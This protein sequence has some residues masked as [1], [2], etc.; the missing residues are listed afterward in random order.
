MIQ[1]SVFPSILKAPQ[2]A[3]LTP[4]ERRA[5]SE[6]EGKRSARALSVDRLVQQDVVF[7]LL[8]GEELNTW[9]HWGRIELIDWSCWFVANWSQPQGGAGVRRFVGAPS[10]PKYFANVGWLVNATVQVRG[11]GELPNVDVVAAPAPTPPDSSVPMITELF[12]G[13]AGSVTGHAPSLP[14]DSSWEAF[15]DDALSGDGYL[16]LSYDGSDLTLTTPVTYP[17]NSQLNINVKFKNSDIGILVPYFQF[18]FGGTSVFLQ[19]ESG[20][21]LTLTISSSTP[22]WISATVD[23]TGLSELDLLINLSASSYKVTANG[24][25]VIDGASY[26]STPPNVTPLAI[27]EIYLA[28]DQ[29]PT[30]DLRVDFVTVSRG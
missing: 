23:I 10:Y 9:L 1:E 29:T 18:F 2:S 13:D 30:P 15:G 20:D 6:I 27:T 28:S 8:N 3:M 17:A 4:A 12:A 14:S 25:V 5:L 22:S 21:G 19:I 24:S 11:R 26:V 7:T 16:V